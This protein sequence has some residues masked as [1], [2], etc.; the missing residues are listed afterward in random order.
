[1][2]WR[3]RLAV[4]AA[5]ATRRRRRHR[6]PR[7]VVLGLTLGTIG[8]LIALWVW[9]F[10][11]I[12]IEPHEWHAR[13]RRLE[14]SIRDVVRGRSSHG[15]DA[16]PELPVWPPEPTN[17]ASALVSCAEAQV[18]RG[19]KRSNTYYSVDWPWGDVPAYIAGPADLIVRCVRALGLD[20]QQL[21]HIDRTANPRRYPLQLWSSRRP[22][23]GIDHRR[24]PNLYAFAQTYFE[25]LPVEAKT[26]EEASL[27]LPG[28]VVFWA[29]GGSHGFPGM[30]GIVTD[31][32]GP[33]GFPWV[34]TFAP[35]E[36]EMSL[37][38]RVNSWPIAAHFRVT[39]DQLLER[40]LEQNPSAVLIPKP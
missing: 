24:L 7:I 13:Q 35:N 30:V 40:F 17:D 27:F 9:V 10:S 26:A 18:A 39:G 12:F 25:N 1:M 36:K 33:D 31:R 28:D 29:P 37:Y 21:L 2:T 38:H 3:R 6:L 20:L 23:R 14:R 5:T 15:V 4:E 32:R 22:D 11:P 34:V 16:V 19:V 8:G